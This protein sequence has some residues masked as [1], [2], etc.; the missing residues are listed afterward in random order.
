MTTLGN[1]LKLNA[2]RKAKR[3]VPVRSVEKELLEYLR[4]APKRIQAN[5]PLSAKQ[6]LNKCVNI[7]ISNGSLSR[8]YDHLSTPSKISLS[9]LRELLQDLGSKYA[10]GFG[11]R[12][13]KDEVW[14]DWFTELGVELAYV[15]A[16]Y[17]LF[18]VVLN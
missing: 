17:A 15:T 7:D 8:I 11:V 3:P 16:G 10:V 18:T 6:L 5:T 12:T 9:R 1:V 13:E 14:L 2:N 4:S